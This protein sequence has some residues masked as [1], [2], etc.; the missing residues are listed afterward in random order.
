[1]GA[2]TTR[3]FVQ[4]WDLI[5]GPDKD[6]LSV[7]EPGMSNFIAQLDM[8]RENGVYALVCGANVTYP[9]NPIYAEQLAWYDLLSNEER[10]NV[11]AFFWS[12]VAQAALDSGNSTTVIGY[13]LM[14]EPRPSTDPAEP[15]YGSAYPGSAAYF[16]PFF[17]R[18][19]PSDQFL[20]KAAEWLTQLTTAIK[21]VDPDALCTLGNFPYTGGVFGIPNT[22]NILD[23]ASPHFY[24]PQ[25][26]DPGTQAFML[27]MIAGWV[28]SDMAVLVGE[29]EGWNTVVPEFN[30]EM[31][32]ALVDG[33]Q[34]IISHNF[35]YGP[36]WFTEPPEVPRPPA[37]PD[38]IPGNYAFFKTSLELFN[39][40]RDSF[41]L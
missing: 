1:M 33:V 16:S 21:A 14:N 29:W 2:N 41:V 8:S 10:W 36:E 39:S 13:D 40:Y 34:G 9:E 31:L 23:F 3:F 4:M 25:T 27:N 22:E 19:I 12:S 15:W 24:P 38:M 28:A 18:G 32:E 11:Q 5:T 20:S 37:L 26:N 35:G 17:A 7:K 30:V 6:N